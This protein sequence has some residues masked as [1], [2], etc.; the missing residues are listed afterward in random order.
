MF[1]CFSYASYLLAESVGLSGIVAVLFCGMTQAHY[2]FYNLSDPSKKLTKDLF[3]LLNFLAE[4]FIFV[5]L[6]L[7]LFTFQNHQWNFGFIAVAIVAMTIS[8]AVHVLPLTW[9][10]N[11]FRK[12]S[13]RISPAFQAMLMWSG[14]RGAIAFSLAMSN[15]S[16]FPH[17]LVLSTTLAI[18][19]FTVL[20]FGGMTSLVMEKLHIKVGV[21]DDGDHQYEF[22][23][24]ERRDR[25]MQKL[26]QTLEQETKVGKQWLMLDNK[27]LKP[28]F[29]LNTV[30]DESCWRSWKMRHQRAVDE[31]H[32]MANE[33]LSARD[34]E[35]DE[36]S[37]VSG[38]LHLEERQ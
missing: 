34:D 14:L 3:G 29:R 18:I 2:T 16:D 4:N 12:P 32:V 1:V 17:Q 38:T 36:V 35:D 10:I 6:G 11:R 23:D 22:D 13:F 21:H 30:Q 19:I 25:N 9:V 24:L 33:L 15:T 5:Y 20:L 37:M 27:Y 26:S 7:S 28:F 8:R 31:T